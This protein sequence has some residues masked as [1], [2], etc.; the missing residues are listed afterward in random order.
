MKET[1]RQI[2]DAWQRAAG[3]AKEAS[4]QNP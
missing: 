2:L 1:P 4:I 3:G